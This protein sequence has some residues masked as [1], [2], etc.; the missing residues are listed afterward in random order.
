MLA[1]IVGAA[2]KPETF[3]SVVE[4]LGRRHALFGVTE[5]HYPAVGEALIW[6]LDKVLGP[7]L[8][9]DAREAW[10]EL[11]RLVQLSMLRGVTDQN[12]RPFV[13]GERAEKAGFLAG[14]EFG[15]QLREQ[16]GE[17]VPGALLLLELVGVG[18]CAARELD[19]LLAHGF[20]CFSFEIGR[21][22]PLEVC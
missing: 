14:A 8:T 19:F 5:A 9:P 12:R 15:G 22:A 16:G 13:V 4:N 2:D 18:A 7:N 17:R 3:A 6:S 1:T 21:S 10:H 20:H 11:Y